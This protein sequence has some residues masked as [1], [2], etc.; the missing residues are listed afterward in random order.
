MVS[1]GITALA[2]A[3]VA[4]VGFVAQCGFVKAHAEG[5]ADLAA[6]AAAD[7]ARGK[8]PGEPCEVAKLM[9]ERE[10]LKM[11]EC[12]ARPDLGSVKVEVKADMPKPVKDLT[13]FA[14]AGAPRTN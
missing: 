3:L 4:G 8:A 6:L 9:I 12:I 13:V 1:V 7:V 14:V 2:V 5:T 11:G 10:D